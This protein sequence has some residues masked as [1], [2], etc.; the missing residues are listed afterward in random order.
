MTIL[1]SALSR[2]EFVFLVAGL[3]MTEA[4]AIDIMLPALPNI[5]QSFAVLNENDRSLVVTVFLYGFG[6]PQVIFGPISD[7]FGRRSLVLGGMAAF[8]ATALLAIASPTFTLLLVFRFLQG[9]AGACV[10][11]ALTACVRDLYSGKA[12]AEIMSL[13]FAVFLLV[14]VI[15]PSVGQFVL[16]AGPWQLIFVVIAAISMVFTVWAGFRLGE[17]L[18]PADRRPLSFKGVTE[19]FAIVFTNRRALFY[20]MSGAFLFAAVMGFILPGQ[21]IFAELYGWG[22]YYPVAMVAIGGTAAV[23]SFIASR[24]IDPIGVRRAAHWSGVLLPVLAFAAALLNVTMGLNAY[25]FLAFVMAFNVP[26]VLGFST[27][28]ALSLEPLGHVAG[29]ASAV[30]G[31]VSTV[32]GAFLSYLI[33]QQYDG[34]TTPILLGIG[35]MGLLAFACYAIAE[36]GKLF[37][38]DPAPLSAVPAEA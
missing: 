29:T 26:L 5:G 10:R 23:S 9:V 35:I 11:V 30:F 13:V 20:G 3:M 16:L 18:A 31:L 14:P 22:P 25:V 21:Q 1:A 27:T 7:R 17:T 24:I 32:G 34:S 38:A 4:L 36:G 19:G 8:I 15:M 12:M 28:G 33:A 2:R 6:L 37:G